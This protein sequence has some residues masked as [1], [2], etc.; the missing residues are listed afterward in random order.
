MSEDHTLPKPDRP[1]TIFDELLRSTAVKETYDSQT[2]GLV[3]EAFGFLIGGSDTTTMSLAYG[4]YFLLTS[5]KQF[6]RLRDE[7]DEA[8]P[9]IKSPDW[10]QI[11]R[12]PYLTAIVKET[13]R[14]SSV[15]PGI[16]PRV[17]P[18]QGATVQ[19][20]FIPGGSYV[21]VSSSLIHGNPALFPEPDAFLP[22]RWLGEQGKL[23]EKWNVAFSKGPRRCIGSS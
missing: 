13:L 10:N 5:P 17:V 6:G 22:E 7:L 11:Q 1:V 20:K 21:S 2:S 19:G 14:L 4:T 12:L 16:L 3:D 15:V 23:L 18:P 9:Y 8:M